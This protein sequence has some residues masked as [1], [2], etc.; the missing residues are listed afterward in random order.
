MKV[1]EALLDSNVFFEPVADMIQL[2]A[3]TSEKESFMCGER[4]KASHVPSRG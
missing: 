2:G 1:T 3:D 4:I